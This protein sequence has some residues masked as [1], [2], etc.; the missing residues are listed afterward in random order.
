MKIQEKK[1]RIRVVVDDD[2]VFHFASGTSLL[3]ILEA[4]GRES[5]HDV[6][7]ANVDN[8][9]LNLHETIQN[10]C[11]IKWLT[12]HTPEG[13]RAY[14]WTLC[15]ILLRAAR[16]I[17]P[18]KELLI[19][20]SL[21]K[22]LYCEFRDHRCQYPRPVRRI[23]RRMLEII[24][25]DEPIRPVKG[26]GMKGAGVRAD[27]FGKSAGK[28][29]LF[30]NPYRCG[31]VTEVL[32]YP[33]LPST[34]RIRAFDLR[35]WS[36]GMILRF[37][38]EKDCLS[39]PPF[40]KQKNLFG[41]FS[42]TR[43]WENILGISTIDDINGN[44]ESGTLPE[45]VKI[46]EGLHEKKIA[47]L[48]DRITE[49]RKKLRVAL[50]AGPSSSGKTTFAKRL[51]IQLRVNGLVPYAL[52]VDDYFLDNTLVPKNDRGKP[53][54]ESIRALNLPRFN[55]DVLGLM[56]GKTVR[57]PRFDFMTGKS[58]QGPLVRLDKCQPILIEGL[59]ALNDELTSAIP[60]ENKFKL[61]VSALTHL[62]I[63]NVMRVSTSDLRLV[64]RIVRDYRF[65]NHSS[66]F[67]LGHW[68]EVRDGEE[69]YIFPFQETADAI[70]NSSL[71]YELGVLGP[72][73][74]PL[75]EK[76]AKTDPSYPEARRLLEYLHFF[77]PVPKCEVPSNSIL[78][79][80]IGGSSFEY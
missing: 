23:R 27:A 4:A 30:F 14:Q 72:L 62:N 9:I 8:R 49:K 42:E 55:S 19:D 22:G 41:V 3:E 29:T 47:A 63:T 1:K 21:G 52:S 79:E 44:T 17:H 74:A 70:F 59:H 60:R 80:F 64:R 6:V 73:A 13:F 28:G 38:D 35:L 76:V 32:G 24:G 77:K 11:R 66:S 53:D 18:K 69:K 34:G 31:E 5:R 71:P 56:E 67:T 50:I 58:V 43:K 48:A 16:D 15:M 51:S 36:P 2:R 7:L 10:R 78:K 12:V 37:P 25:A 20:H 45:L 46:A 65:R 61:Y 33:L 68:L 75:L 40:V 54:F 39:L 26:H 57:L